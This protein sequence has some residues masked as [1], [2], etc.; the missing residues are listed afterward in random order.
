MMKLW[1]IMLPILL[2]IASLGLASCTGDEKTVVTTPTSTPVATTSTSEITEEPPEYTHQI[3][4]IGELGVNEYS[5]KIPGQSTILPRAYPGAPPFVPHSLSGLVI[6]KD[7]LPCL[8]C[9]LQGLS[10]GTD[11]TATKIHESHYIDLPT[12]IKSQDI[13]P[14]RYNCLICHVPQS[15]KNTPLE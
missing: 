5:T 10:L 14:I 12:G 11:H 9:H 6:T 4:M 1:Y 2:I 8:T 3:P 7:Q 15:L 13:Q